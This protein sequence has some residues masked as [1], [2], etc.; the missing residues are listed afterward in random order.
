MLVFNPPYVPTGPEE[1]ASSGIEAAWAGGRDGRE[2]CLVP[3]AL[4]VAPCMDTLS[5]PVI[6]SSSLI[7]EDGT[8]QWDQTSNSILIS[9]EWG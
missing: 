5:F 6:R 8:R 1:M 2:V 4:R 3:P 7:L 9:T